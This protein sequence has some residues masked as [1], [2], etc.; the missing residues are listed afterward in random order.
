[1]ASRLFRV[2]AYLMS[3]ISTKT[4][5]HYCWH[6][7][8]NAGHTRWER[9]G[10]KNFTQTTKPNAIFYDAEI[11]KECGLAPEMNWYCERHWDAMVARMES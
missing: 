10:W 5:R 2:I 11:V 9:I 3:A 8:L 4:P 7:Y 1:M 6:C